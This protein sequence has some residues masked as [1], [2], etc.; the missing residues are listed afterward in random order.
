[1]C[2]VSM[3]SSMN[4]ER[5]IGNTSSNLTKEEKLWL[6]TKTIYEWIEAFNCMMKFY[7]TQELIDSFL[8]YEQI[9]ASDYPLV[10]EW[11]PSSPKYLLNQSKNCVSWLGN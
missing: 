9:K 8:I 3:F 10:S 6:I 7:K 1:M 2:F 5:L 11:H 4:C